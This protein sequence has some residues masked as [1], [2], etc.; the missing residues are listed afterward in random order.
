MRWLAGNGADTA[1]D[2]LRRVEAK[3][4]CAL[5]PRPPHSKTLARG[6]ALA[7]VQGAKCVK[8]SGLSTSG[9]H[10]L[11]LLS[12]CTGWIL[13]PKLRAWRIAAPAHSQCLFSCRRDRRGIR[14]SR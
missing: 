11:V 3:A 13:Q 5:T 9:L 4:V 10:Y 2:G 12:V 7:L 6:P 8:M 14:L 1:L